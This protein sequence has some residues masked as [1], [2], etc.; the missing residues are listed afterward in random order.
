MEGGTEH[1]LLSLVNV[2]S[3]EEESKELEEEKAEEKLSEK[4]ETEEGE[5]HGTDSPKK[6][7]D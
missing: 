2:E 7:E 3:A 1:D 4:S 5:N 6:G